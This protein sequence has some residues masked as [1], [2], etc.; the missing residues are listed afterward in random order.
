VKNVNK[1]EEN[2]HLDA[3]LVLA[4]INGGIE[5]IMNY[6]FARQDIFPDTDTVMARC[7]WLKK[8]SKEYISSVSLR[9]AELEQER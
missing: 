8:Q 6:A 5:G 9:V 3:E 2:I 1:F 7:K 4:G